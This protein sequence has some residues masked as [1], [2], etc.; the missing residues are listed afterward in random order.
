MEHRARFPESCGNLAVNLPPGFMAG[1]LL[2]L[3]NYAMS[4][5][6]YFN[7]NPKSNQDALDCTVRAL[8]A[9]L[10]IDWDWAYCMTSAQGFADK[11]M[12]VRNSVWSSVL[13]RHGFRRAVIPNACPDCYTAEDFCVDNP[14]GTFVLCFD[15]HVAAVIDGYVW[16]LDD[17]TR[18]V[19]QYYWYKE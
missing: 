16:D 1:R 12:P 7:P 4:R 5:W 11:K 17:S 10:D 15:Q 14:R 3:Y 6:R 8:C 2:F 19:P 9:V 13:R 18:M